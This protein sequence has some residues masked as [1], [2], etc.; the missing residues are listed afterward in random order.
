M[1]CS[2]PFALYEDVGLFVIVV[3]IYASDEFITRQNNRDFVKT[4][5]DV[6]IPG[7]LQRISRGATNGGVADI[8][9]IWKVLTFEEIEVGAFP[10]R[11]PLLIHQKYISIE[12]NCLDLVMFEL[13]MSEVARHW[14]A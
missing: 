6:W 8:S 1:K 11:N 7:N 3:H 14:E 13:G 5:K 2:K 4:I 12:R 10:F 9:D